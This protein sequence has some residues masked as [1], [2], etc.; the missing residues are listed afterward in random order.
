MPANNSNIF[1]SIIETIEFYDN[2]LGLDRTDSLTGT[3]KVK[4]KTRG[5]GLAKV[6]ATF[7]FKDEF[8]AGLGSKGTKIKYKDKITNSIFGDAENPR[9]VRSGNKKYDYYNDGKKIVELSI[10]PQFIAEFESGKKIKGFFRV[11]LDDDFIAI[12]KGDGSDFQDNKV[13]TADFEGDLL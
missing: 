6:K 1:S 10:E 4:R 7:Q 8:V 12:S 9:T 11:S 3:F 2:L 5:N 13:L